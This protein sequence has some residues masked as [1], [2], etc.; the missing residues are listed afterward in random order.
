MNIFGSVLWR[1]VR[2]A[3]S[4]GIASAAAWVAHDPRWIWLA[5]VISAVG[6]LLRE[7]YSITNI[8]L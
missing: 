1:L 4:V 3:A 8:P 7:K 5:P 6:K 2:V